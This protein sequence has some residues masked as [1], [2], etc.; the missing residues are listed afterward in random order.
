MLILF[1]GQVLAPSFN[2][3]HVLALQTQ[4]QGLELTQELLHDYESQPN[5]VF[6][7]FCALRE[8]DVE[9]I[10]ELHPV[11]M[12][13]ELFFRSDAVVMLPMMEYLRLAGDLVLRGDLRLLI[14]IIASC[15]PK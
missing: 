11:E 15:L 3:E 13:E 6:A 2:A 4:L 8:E 7:W 1:L 10:E 5:S 14:L 9:L 12:A